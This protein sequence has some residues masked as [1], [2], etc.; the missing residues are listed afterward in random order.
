MPGLHWRFNALH[1]HATTGQAVLA[2]ASASD[3]VASQIVRSASE[4]LASQVALLVNVLDPE[5]VVIGG[6]LGLSQ[7]PYWEH[8]I[9]SSRRHIW[10]VRHRELPILR[11]A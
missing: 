4:A 9:A 10:S 1:G 11:A 5:A 6:G 3:A 2:A 7:G 8:L